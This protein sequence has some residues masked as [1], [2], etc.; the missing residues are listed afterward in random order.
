MKAPNNVFGVQS[1]S[2]DDSVHEVFPIVRRANSRTPV[3]TSTIRGANYCYAEFGNHAGMWDN[4]SPEITERD[5][6]YARKLGINQIRCFITYQPYQR[7]PNQYRRNLL[8]LVRAADQRGIG[9]MPVVGYGRQMQRADAPGL[10][11]WAKFLVDTLGK[12]PGLAFWDVYNEP[13]YPPTPSLVERRTA[14]AQHMA[15]V[16]RRLDGQTPVTIGFAFAKTMAKYVDDVDVLVFHNYL[17][18]REQIRA[19][20]EL[21]KKVSAEARKQVIDDEM[22]CVARANPYDITIEEHIKANIGFYVWELMVVHDRTT[23]RGWGSIHG[24]FYPD[25]TVRDPSIPLAVMGIFR[26]R[27][28]DVVLE[29]PDREGRVTRVIGDAQRWL[30]DPNS[31]WESGLDI[32]EI[33]ANLMESG[34]LVPM[35]ELP[36][37]QVILLRQGQEDRQALKAILEK[38]IVLLR[39]YVKETD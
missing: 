5:L 39:P 26:N 6:N 7:D 11:E 36:T 22:G 27:G 12:E 10:E 13:D 37:R 33:A 29:E 17:E 28:P 21:A 30:G 34:Q 31:T 18:T 2:D 32:A 1:K 15:G 25:G 19:D 23:G 38:D 14:F 20:I 16:F 35:R 24:I 9:V 3:D 8:H 4:Y